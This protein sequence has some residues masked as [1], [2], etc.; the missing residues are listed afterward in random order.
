MTDYKAPKYPRVQVR[1]ETHKKL[2]AAAD[3][4]QI[5]ITELADGIFEN[6]LTIKK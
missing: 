4:A 3:Q 6:A 1:P 2:Q 5:S